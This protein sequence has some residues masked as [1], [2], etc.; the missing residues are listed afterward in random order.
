M[1]KYDLSNVLLLA[2]MLESSICR[3]TNYDSVSALKVCVIGWALLGT[4]K[5]VE[6]RFRRMCIAVSPN[7]KVINL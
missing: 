5:D 6:I 1:S 7:V 2:Q 4:S 3:M